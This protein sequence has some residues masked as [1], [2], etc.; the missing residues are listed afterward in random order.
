M[1][2]DFVDLPKCRMQPCHVVTAMVYNWPKIGWNKEPLQLAV[3]IY[4]TYKLA[5]MRQIQVDTVPV[6]VTRMVGS[7]G[8]EW[9]INYFNACYDTL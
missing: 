6:L 1:E 5:T 7:Y 9:I 2:T 8:R 4:C 3:R